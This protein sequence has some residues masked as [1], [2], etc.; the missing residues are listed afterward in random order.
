VKIA[1]TIAAR[2]AFSRASEVREGLVRR[3][4]RAEQ[5]ALREAEHVERAEHDAGQAAASSASGALTPASNCG[6]AATKKP[7][8]ARNS[9]GEAAG[10]GQPIE[11]SV[12]IAKN[13]A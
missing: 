8:S 4:H 11:A 12:R 2:I 1:S 6:H 13:T 10:R 5:E 9:P 7:R 3:L